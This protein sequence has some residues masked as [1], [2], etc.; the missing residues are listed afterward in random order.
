L[1]PLFLNGQP[2][3]ELRPS[4]TGFSHSVPERFDMAKVAKFKS[5]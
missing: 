3:M 2:I 5:K 1:L 4:V